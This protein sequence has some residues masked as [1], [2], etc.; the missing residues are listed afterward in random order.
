M[1]KLGLLLALGALGLAGWIAYGQG[2]RDAQIRTLSEDTRDLQDTL[3]D[4]RAQLD[5]AKRGGRGT[6]SLLSEEGGAQTGAPR[7][8]QG[9]GLAVREASSAPAAST[10]ERIA[11]LEKTIA[12]LESEAKTSSHGTPGRL[13][14]RDGMYFNLDSAARSMGLDE[15]QKSDLQ[16]AL[17]RGRSELEDLYKIENDDG[18]TWKQVRKP[19]MAQ[20]G[21][22]TGFSIGL[23]NFAKIAAFKKSRIPGSSETF[24][25]AEQRIKEGAFA[26]ARRTLTPK[27]AKKW[28]AAHKDALLGGRGVATSIAFTSVGVESEK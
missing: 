23:P 9:A 15:R 13:F 25:E 18:V 6:P 10:D 5:A 11:T 4:L 8:P 1:D 22:E 16:E 3:S 19:K 24:G 7:S 20:L 27:Q 21:G 2:E 14:S 28:D 26:N 17:D 12:R